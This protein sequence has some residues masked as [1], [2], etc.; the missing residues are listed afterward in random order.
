MDY[1][2]EDAK[3]ICMKYDPNRLM[4]ISDNDFEYIHNY[5]GQ[6][7]ELYELGLLRQYV[8]LG[9]LKFRL[10]ERIKYIQRKG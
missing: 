1:T 5:I 10:Q 4:D 6:C 2:Y 9:M 7:S 3:R 8:P